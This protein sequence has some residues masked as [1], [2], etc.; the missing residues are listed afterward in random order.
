MGS[1]PDQL[2][3]IGFLGSG[4]IVAAGFNGYGGS[5]TTAAGQ[6]AAMMALTGATPDWVPEDVFSP[7]RFLDTEPLFLRAQESLWRI[8]ASLCRQLRTVEA[9]AAEILAYAAP[10]PAGRPVRAAPASSQSCRLG[11][12]HSPLCPEV[13]ADSLRR[14]ATFRYFSRDEL[15]QLVRLMRRWEAPE[16]A[17]LMTEGD[18]GGAASSSSAARRR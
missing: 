17:C 3:A 6:A 15:M 13:D 7:R 11:A 10:Q 4:V 9:Q 5:Y 2:P 18:P 8:A 12:R 1:T 16:G 14:F